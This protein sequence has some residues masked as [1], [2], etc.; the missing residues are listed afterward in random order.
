MFDFPR[1]FTQFPNGFDHTESPRSI[2]Q[3]LSPHTICHVILPLFCFLRYYWRNFIIAV[4]NLYC[5]SWSVPRMLIVQ[6]LEWKKLIDLQNN[7][8]I[9]SWVFIEYHLF[10]VSSQ[11]L[12]WTACLTAEIWYLTSEI[13]PPYYKLRN[14]PGAPSPFLH[15]FFP[16]ILSSTP[17]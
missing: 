14:V 5:F 6:S 12:A 13:A 16:H 8:Y 1:C 15:D 2:S 7:N 11:I 10:P 17:P 3:L 9:I 4:N